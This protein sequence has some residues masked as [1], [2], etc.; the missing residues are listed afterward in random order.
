MPT[1]VIQ[2]LSSQLL[3]ADKSTLTRTSKSLHQV[4]NPLLYKDI[5]SPATH[6]LLRKVLGSQKAANFIQ[7]VN[8][9]VQDNGE[10]FE[11]NVSGLSDRN[12]EAI[13]AILKESDLHPSITWAEPLTAEEYWVL[14][15]RQGNLKVYQA[16]FLSQLSNLASLTIG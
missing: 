10:I 8:F 15:I 3:T 4:V 12:F 13:L 11:T 2:L 9:V 5:H 14:L 1:E 16:I 6:L 7:N